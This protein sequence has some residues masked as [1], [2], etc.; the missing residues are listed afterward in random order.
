MWTKAV[1]TKLCEI[2]QGRFGYRVYARTNEV[3]EAYRDGG[4]WLYDVTWLEYKKSDLTELVD[5][6]LV[7]ECEWGGFAAIVEA[8]SGV[9]LAFDIQITRPFVFGRNSYQ[10]PR[11]D[12]APLSGFFDADYLLSVF[13]IGNLRTSYRMG[14]TTV[15]NGNRWKSVSRVQIR[16]MPCSRINTAV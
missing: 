12:S 3:D 8:C 16:L 13:A 10:A 11:P 7:A 6:P 4:E 1:K 15:R 9:W 2:G 14:S 5:A